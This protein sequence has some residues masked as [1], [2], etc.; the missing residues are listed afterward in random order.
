MLESILEMNVKLRLNVR[1]VLLRGNEKESFEEILDIFREIYDELGFPER[2]KL[3][4]ELINK[5]PVMGLKVATS[6]LSGD[7]SEFIYRKIAGED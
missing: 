7:L 2:M 4:E 6:H 5:D 3:I 1:R